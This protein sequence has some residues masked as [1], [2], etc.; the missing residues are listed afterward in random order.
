LRFTLP[1]KLTALTASIAVVLSAPASAHRTVRPVEAT[2]VAKLRGIV[3]HYRTLTWTWQRAAR[4]RK[5]ATTFSD[6]RSSDRGYLHW[7]VDLWTRRAYTARH[8][9]LLALGH[10][11]DVALPREPG[12]RTRL[13]TRLA[14]ER[15]LALRLRHIYP[16][17]VPRG[18]ATVR[19][20]GTAALFVWQ[21]RGAAAALGVSRHG[22]AHSAVPAVLVRAFGC[23]HTFE[24]AWDANTG[25]GY[26][27]GLQMDL[28]FQQRYGNEFVHRW[29]TADNWPVWAQL[30]AAAR[31]YRSG[32]GF[33]PWPNTAR[34]CGLI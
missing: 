19:V 16:G 7:T 21:Q 20:G 27:G 28:G 34:V 4:D 30:T 1:L 31:A 25:N 5:T 23:I 22:E 26:Y 2:S 14:Y 18:F 12:L 24:G 32:R 8:R 29:G 11:F 3:D 15:H 6:H 10:R 33:S 9:A 17:R 13:A